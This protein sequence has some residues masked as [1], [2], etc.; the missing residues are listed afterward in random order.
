[1]ADMKLARCLIGISSAVV[2]LSADTEVFSQPA[3]QA[4]QLP[5]QQWAVIQTYCVGC[6][7]RVVKAGNILFDQ[8]TAESVPQH[9]ETFEK[10]VRKLRGRLMPPPGNPQPSQE[11]INALAGWLE[12]TLD[13]N[14]DVA[15]AGHVPVQ[16]LNRTEY[17][18][19]VKDLLAVEIDP[20]QYLPAEIEV[21]G[22]SN[23]AS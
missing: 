6:H 2:I 20:E 16:R 14:S 21:E 5:G 1:M 15:K 22:F 18:N 3:N 7:N 19:A 9:P 4:A 13:K 8:L 17:A 11:E 23:I 10:A 12:N